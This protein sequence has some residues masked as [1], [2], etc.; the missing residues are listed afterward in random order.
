[1]P[2]QALEKKRYRGL[3]QLPDRLGERCQRWLYELGPEWV[4][5]G[6]QRHRLWNS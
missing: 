6:D 3:G 2:L 1:M 4:I 5:D